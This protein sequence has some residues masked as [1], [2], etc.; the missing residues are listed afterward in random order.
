M[1][2]NKKKLP[3]AIR[4]EDAGAA[5]PALVVAELDT[6]APARP[7]L[8]RIRDDDRKANDRV[9]GAS[10]ACRKHGEGNNAQRN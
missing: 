6:A 5:S 4:P 7:G 2:V 8:E 1:T 3:R 9:C 10:Q